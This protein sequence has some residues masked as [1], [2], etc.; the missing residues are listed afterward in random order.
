MRIACATASPICL[1]ISRMHYVQ[2]NSTA[3]N[4]CAECSLGGATAATDDV[5]QPI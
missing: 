3:S 1:A 5:T 4:Q 2:S